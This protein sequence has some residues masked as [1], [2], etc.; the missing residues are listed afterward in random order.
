MIKVEDFPKNANY[1]SVSITSKNGYNQPK[2]HGGD[3]WIVRLIAME[4][5]APDVKQITIPPVSTQN[6]KNGSY[7]FKMPFLPTNYIEK[8]NFK[9]EVYLIRSAE[10]MEVNRRAMSSYNMVGRT[11]RTDLPLK[12]GG[13]KP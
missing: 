5:P 12:T 9:L 2:T 1:F 10:M 3:Y 13:H 4:R 11:M 7:S 6:F 8:L